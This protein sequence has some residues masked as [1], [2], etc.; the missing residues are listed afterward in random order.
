MFSLLQGELR[1]FVTSVAS[2][3][4]IYFLLF[5]GRNISTG[6]VTNFFLIFRFKFSCLFLDSKP[7]FTHVTTAEHYT[8]P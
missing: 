4:H 7:Y 2:K 1:D 5:G 6:T 8:C 3:V